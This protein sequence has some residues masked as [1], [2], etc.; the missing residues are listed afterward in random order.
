MEIFL[1]KTAR[2]YVFEQQMLKDIPQMYT[3][4]YVNLYAHIEVFLK[5]NNIVTCSHFHLVGL[6]QFRNVVSGL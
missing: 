5:V 2:R 3:Y 1:K 6:E 4:V